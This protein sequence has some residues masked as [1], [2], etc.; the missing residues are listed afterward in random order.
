MI[1]LLGLALCKIENKNDL[2]QAPLYSFLDKGDKVIVDTARGQ[3]EAVVVSTCSAMP[4]SDELSMIMEAAGATMPLKMVLKKIR[5]E[6][7]AYSDDELKLEAEDEDD[8]KQ[9]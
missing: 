9:V 2:F 8:D 1:K 7:L 3:K 6:D 5:V 4:G